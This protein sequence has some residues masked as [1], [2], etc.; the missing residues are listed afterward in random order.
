MD[1]EVSLRNEGD[2]PRSK[3]AQIIRAAVEHF[4]EFGYAETKWSTIAKQVGIGQTGLYHYFESKTHCLLAVLRIVMERSHANMTLAQ[5]E[6]E[7]AHSALRLYLKKTFEISEFE[8]LQLRILQENLSILSSPRTK[9]KVEEKE[10]RIIRQLVRS[11]E[12]RMSELLHQAME[13][14]LIPQR[15]P[16]LLARVVLGT[17]TSVWR[18]YRVG[19]IYKVDEAGDFVTEACCRMISK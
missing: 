8:Q 10:R 16:K 15:D 18:W 4:G 13:T 9:S 19:G 14:G 2:G 17:V 1:L 6:T 5:E 7:D 11:L 3:R 12:T